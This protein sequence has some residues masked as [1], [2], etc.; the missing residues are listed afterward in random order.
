VQRITDR[1]NVM[2]AIGRVGALEVVAR[3]PAIHHDG[4]IGGSPKPLEPNAHIGNGGEHPR[5]ALKR[6]RADVASLEHQVAGAPRA[7]EPAGEQDRLLGRAEGT[8]HRRGRGHRSGCFHGD[9]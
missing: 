6:A 3:N 2:P 7:P 9:R 1:K 8:Q 4:P 5:L